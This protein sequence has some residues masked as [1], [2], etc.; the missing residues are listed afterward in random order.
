[1]ID[2]DTSCELTQPNWQSHCDHKC[3][4][5]LDI[6]SKISIL[7]KLCTLTIFYSI[8][9]IYITNI[10]HAKEQKRSTRP[11]IQ[12]KL[13]SDW[14]DLNSMIIYSMLGFLQQQNASA[15]I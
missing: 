15:E 3:H 4:Q 9:I 8:V 7:P 2:H 12:F 5:H 14:E 11:A 1:M 10:S 13:N 6:Q